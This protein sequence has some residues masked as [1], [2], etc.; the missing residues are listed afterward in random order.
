MIRVLFWILLVANI[1]LFAAMQWGANLWGEPV[2]TQPPLNADKMRLLTAN[3]IASADA[4]P[5]AHETPQ[6]N[7]PELQQGNVAGSICLE[8]SGILEAESAAAETYLAQ[9]QLGDKLVKHE[10]EHAI[11]FWVFIPP[12]KDKAAID[13]KVN[14]LQER[15]V[16]EYFVVQEIG[17]WLNAISLGVFRTQEAAQ[18]ALVALRSK[19]VRSAQVGQRNSKLKMN[20]FTLSGVNAE[21]EA[22][23]NELQ[24]NLAGSEVKNVSCGLTR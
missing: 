22:N 2:A 1:V 5:A 11:D 10:V 14:Q 21:I 19:G 3:Q 6:Q 18:S 23:L 8:W 17:V 9:L 7:S 16:K 13:E 4:P 24:K 20:S 15:G 12:L